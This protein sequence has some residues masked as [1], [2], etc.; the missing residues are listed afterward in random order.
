MAVNQIASLNYGPYFLFPF[1]SGI[2]ATYFCSFL[3][4]LFTAT[5][6]KSKLQTPMLLVLQI[7]T[8]HGDHPGV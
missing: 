1:H 5:H 2:C 6:G 8:N 4:S 3:F 7:G